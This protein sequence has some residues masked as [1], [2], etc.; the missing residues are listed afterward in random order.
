MATTSKIYKY[1]FAFI[2][3]HKYTVLYV[4]SRFIKNGQPWSTF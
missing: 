2:K 3:A 1:E 4:Y